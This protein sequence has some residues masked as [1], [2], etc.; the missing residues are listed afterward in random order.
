MVPTAAIAVGGYILGRVSSVH[1]VTLRPLLTAKA[2]IRRADL[3]GWGAGLGTPRGQSPPSPRPRMDA[4][5][6]PARAGPRSSG[7]REH[8]S[9]ASPCRGA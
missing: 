5:P 4:R 6:L 9:R 1:G 7:F 8:P 3:P 2:R